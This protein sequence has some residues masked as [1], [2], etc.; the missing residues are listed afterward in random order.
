M[1]RMHVDAD[2]R[3][4]H[5]KTWRQFMPKNKRVI[6]YDAVSGLR[7][8]WSHPVLPVFRLRSLPVRR[9]W[10]G[11]RPDRS[12]A[13]PTWARCWPCR[14]P[15]RPVCGPPIWT[16]LPGTAAGPL[17]RKNVPPWA[18]ITRF[19]NSFALSAHSKAAW[20]SLKTSKKTIKDNK[21]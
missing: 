20:S 18:D 17:G 9:T 21:A 7:R 3:R 4:A 12:P 14:W 5:D 15:R 6:I 8:R 11:W 10:A 19:T 13:F 16:A 1:D 2:V